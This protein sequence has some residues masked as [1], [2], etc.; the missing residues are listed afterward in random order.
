MEKFVLIR[1]IWDE[2]QN[3]MYREKEQSKSNEGIKVSLEISDTGY[4][5]S[6]PEDKQIMVKGENK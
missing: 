2:C 4:P 6:V 3:G 5:G 1:H